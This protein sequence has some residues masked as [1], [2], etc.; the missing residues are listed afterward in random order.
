MLDKREKSGQTPGDAA[1]MRQQAEEQAR[2]IESTIQ[3]PQAPEEIQRVFHELRVH[4]IE[5]EMQNEELRRAQTEIEAGRARYYDLYDL[6]PVGYCTLSE[7]GLILEANLT[8]ATLL[9]VSCGAMVKQPLSRFIFKEDQ[10]IYY[11]HRKKLFEKGEHQECELRLVQSDGALFWAHLTA[12]ATQSEDGA[13]VCRVVLTDIT[14]QKNAEEEIQK[15]LCEK[16]ILLREVHHRVKNNIASIENLLSFQ[17]GSTANSEVSL[18]LQDAIS[19]VQSM[20]ILYDNLLMTD[21][22]NEIPIRS[23]TENLI[24]SFVA[25]FILKNNITIE[26]YIANFEIN[27][28][29]AISI[30]IIINELLTNIIKYAFK[31]RDKGVVSVSIDKIDNTVII[32]IQ[33]N[34]IGMDE[35]V[36]KNKLPGFGLTIVKMLVKHLNGTYSIVNENGTRNIIKFK[37]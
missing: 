21:D 24:D 22:Y 16:E 35:S 36:M 26:R 25:V 14:E 2:S 18:A 31:G 19:R 6:A 23:Y 20:R 33:D 8:A 29:K 28:N 5:L 12:T 10:D 13:T 32:V 1:A 27:S 30:G 4:Q 9:G 37:I 3:S 11:L 17:A 15:Q 34:G 7:K